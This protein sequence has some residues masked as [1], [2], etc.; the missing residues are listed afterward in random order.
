MKIG[1][2]LSGGGIRGVA[3]LGVIKALEE[4]GVNFDLL[5]GTSAGSIVGAFYAAGYSVDRILEI[6][7]DIK[8]NKFIRLAL[9]WKGVLKM[10]SVKQFLTEYF[11]HDSFDDLN[12]PLHIA[13]T[14]IQKGETEY[15]TEGSLTDAICASSCIPVLF[16]PVS[17]N[18]QLYIDG[19]I[20]NNLPVEAI[21]KS[22]DIVVGSHSNPIGDGFYPKNAK[23][24]MERTL[25]LAIT[26]NAYASRTFCDYFIEPV[27]LEPFHVL[28]INKAKEIY[29]IGY[30]KGIEYLENSDLV[31]RVVQ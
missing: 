9:S 6:V 26:R 7:L 23:V 20:L 16:D 31:K 8:T 30:N 14:N 13:A 4:Y 10:N 25:M 19:G 22:C 17:I 1:L 24:V 29:N 28:D 21:R 18:G 27:G 15:F 2:V 11:P 3:H 12:M 5:A